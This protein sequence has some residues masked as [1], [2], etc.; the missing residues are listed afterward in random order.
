MSRRLRKIGLVLVGTLGALVALEL[1][2]Q[3]GAFLLHRSAAA[4]AGAGADVTVLCVGDSFTYG[5]GAADP[6]Q[7]YPSVM[8]RSPRLAGVQVINLGWPGQDSGRVLAR[9]P[10]QLA[11]TR[12]SAAV[13]S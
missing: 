10:D 7:S 6:S 1:V 11:T 9:L 12:P 3:V 13:V 8:A 5:L 2:L 4:P